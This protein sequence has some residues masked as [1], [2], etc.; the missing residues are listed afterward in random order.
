[1]AVLSNTILVPSAEIAG[2]LLLPLPSLPEA[3]FDHRAVETTLTTGA[4]WAQA[5]IVPAATK[6]AT[7]TNCED[8]RNRVDI[9]T[10]CH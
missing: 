3:F 10:S 8:V 9:S 5:S 6:P 2:F 7:R 4:C 1:V